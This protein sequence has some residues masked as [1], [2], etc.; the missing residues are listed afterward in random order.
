MIIVVADG[1]AY[2]VE[3]RTLDEAIRKIGKAH[4]KH[5]ISFLP[6]DIHVYYSVLEA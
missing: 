1:R 6:C 4:C 2:Q 5:N 3:A